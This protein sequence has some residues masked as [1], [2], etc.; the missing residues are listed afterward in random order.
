MD[1]KG[2][3]SNLKGFGQWDS[4]NYPLRQEEA[5]VIIEAL[6][7]QEPV[8]AVKQVTINDG[9]SDE[10][11]SIPVM[12]GECSECGCGVSSRYVFCPKCGRKL[13]WSTDCEG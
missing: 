10:T 8:K 6:E 5:V 11:V 2:V 1:R 13:D 3:L 12:L 9:A 7:E 4:T